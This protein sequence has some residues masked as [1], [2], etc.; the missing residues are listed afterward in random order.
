MVKLVFHATAL[1]V[2]RGPPNMHTQHSL[3]D[4]RRGLSRGDQ[5]SVQHHADLA[6]Q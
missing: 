2:K 6:A 1:R 3:P 4:T 5:I